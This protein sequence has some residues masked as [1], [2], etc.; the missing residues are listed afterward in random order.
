MVFFTFSSF[1]MAKRE[2]DG[3]PLLEMNKLDV[4][5][6]EPRAA[7]TVLGTGDFGKALAQRLSLVGYDVVI[8]SRS[9]EKRSAT[10]S[11]NYRILSI[12]DAVNHSDIVFLAIPRDGYQQMA[13]LLQTRVD[14]KIVVDVSNRTDAS[15][16]ATSHAEH[17]ASLLPAARVVKGF[18]VV[19][20]WA[21]ENDIYGGSRLVYVCGDDPAAKTEV[22]HRFYVEG[23]S[24]PAIMFSLIMFSKVIS[25]Y[26]CSN[27]CGFF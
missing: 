5:P 2:L 7:V 20:A 3:K 16:D 6:I 22:G 25:Y 19:S 24:A 26:F 10:L 18:N 21:L 14:N 9:A 12:E 1:I 4:G 27:F 23:S 13:A 8:G 11:Q 15:R 17:L